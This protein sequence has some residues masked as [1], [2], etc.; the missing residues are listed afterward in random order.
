MMGGE[1]P[2]ENVSSAASALVARGLSSLEGFEPAESGRVPGVPRA[3]DEL[4]S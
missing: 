1:A 2:I 3:V 4:G